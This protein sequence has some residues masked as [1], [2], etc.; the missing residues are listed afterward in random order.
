MPVISDTQIAGAAKTAGFTGKNLG[1][2]VAVAL[3][4]SG[5]NTDATNSNSNKSTDY[6]LWQINSVHSQLL[7]GKNWRDPN[8]NA[9]MA[10]SISGGGTNWRPWTVFKSGAYVRFLSR[11]NA[12]AGNP[13]DAPGGSGAPPT[14]AATDPTSGLAYFTNPGLWARVGIFIMGGALLVFALWKLTGVGGAVVS[15]AKTVV[16]ARTGLAL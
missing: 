5:G 15:T 11:G 16:K 3:A 7:A 14:A 2:A 13:S 4:E 9:Q 8:T 12:A 1:I 10:F 6:G